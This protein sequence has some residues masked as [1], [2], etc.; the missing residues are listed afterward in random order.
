MPP[1]RWCRRRR[2]LYGDLQGAAGRIMQE[3]ESLDVL[4]IETTADAAE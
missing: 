2:G 4:M 3:I 1:Q